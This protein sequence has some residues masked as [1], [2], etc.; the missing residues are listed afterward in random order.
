[1]FDYCCPNCGTTL[2]YQDGFDRYKKAWICTECHEPILNPDDYSGDYVLTC[3]QCG[4]ILNNQ[5]GYYYGSDT[6][7]CT[8][9][10]YLNDISH[11]DLEQ[12]FQAEEHYCPNCSSTLEYQEGFD[13][14]LKAWICTECGAKLTENGNEIVWLCDKCEAILN[15]QDN[16]SDDLS[17]WVCTECGNVNYLNN[18]NIF[19]NDDEYLEYKR[20]INCCPACGDNFEYQFGEDSTG[21]KICSC[22]ERLYFC[23]KCFKLLNNQYNFD[24]ETSVECFIC[25]EY[26]DLSNENYIIS[27]GKCNEILNN[28]SGFKR[29]YDSWTCFNCG[30]TNKLSISKQKLCENNNS[31]CYEI[32]STEE[33]SDFEKLE[34]KFANLA[35]PNKVKRSR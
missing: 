15:N 34:D 23:Q 9:C 27:C 22:G 11:N 20:N 8:E 24:T 18:N 26:N 2:E 1:M 31:F 5:D 17:E 3:S 21:L 25:G 28:Q 35:F 6:Q 16:F 10:G 13:S 14:S 19:D 32:P 7:F 4:S 30:V 12:N 33:Y 29:I